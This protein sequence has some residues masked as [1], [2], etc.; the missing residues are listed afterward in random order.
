MGCAGMD[1]DAPYKLQAQ[2]FADLARKEREDAIALLP[3]EPD[4][5]L[6]YWLGLVRTLDAASLQAMFGPEKQA[7]LKVDFTL[8]NWGWNA[9]TAHLLKQRPSA[10]T[11][12]SQQS[13]SSGT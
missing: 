10:T 4:A 2:Y 1:R 11:A 5:R 3:A 7:L 9:A 12:P 13:D 8:L 6:G